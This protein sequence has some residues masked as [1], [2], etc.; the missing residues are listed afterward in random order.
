MTK[1]TVIMP[2]E[3]QFRFK[4]IIEENQANSRL[5]KEQLRHNF[6]TLREITD[7]Q[8]RLTGIFFHEVNLKR[9]QGLVYRDNLLLNNTLFNLPYRV[10]SVL[11]LVE[12]SMYGA[13]RPILRQSFEQT[14]LAKQSELDP[15][16][17][18][19]WHDEERIGAGGV[20]DRLTKNGNDVSTLSEFWRTL[21]RVTHAT[22]EA[23]QPLLIPQIHESQEIRPWFL[24]SPYQDEA[25]DHGSVMES[26][27]A[28]SMFTLDML[29]AVLGMN[30]HL[31][32]GHFGRKARGYFPSSRDPRDISEH[33]K[34]LKVRASALM[35]EYSDHIPSKGR[36]YFRRVI[37]Q[38]RQNW[39]QSTT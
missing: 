13:A 25:T 19:K 20:I 29:Y 4:A 27:V 38:F 14:I 24:E 12:N 6:K 33:E 28:N 11:L 39:R 5:I 23:M 36:K 30:L 8:S 16:M 37:F 17:T 31:L 2:V 21:N 18:A 9:M 22:R 3:G 32:V 34:E 1:D 35:R 26:L 10:F 15:V 7:C